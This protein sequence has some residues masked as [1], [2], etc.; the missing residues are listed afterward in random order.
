MDFLTEHKKAIRS[1]TNSRNRKKGAKAEDVAAEALRA[2]GYACVEPIET[3]WT[4]IRK[5]NPVKK[6]SVI[7]S[8]FPKKKVSGD[9]KAI[10]PGS[11]RMVHVEVKSYLGNLAFSVLADHQVEALDRVNNYG[12][13]G[14]ASCRERV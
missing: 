3:G 7:A 10:Q 11:G 2:A 9:I 12:E 13:I 1:A 5:Y 6:T 14:R 8:A 4:I